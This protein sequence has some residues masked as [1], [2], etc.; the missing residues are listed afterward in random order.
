MFH[1]WDSHGNAFISASVMVSVASY[2]KYSGP[3][4][5]RAAFQ[6]VKTSVVAR[7]AG[8]QAVELLGLREVRDGGVGVY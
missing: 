5:R 3:N 1:G 6:T 7:P 8:R 2:D 4:F